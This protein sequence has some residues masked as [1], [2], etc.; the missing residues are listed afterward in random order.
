MSKNYPKEMH[1]AE[2]I[3]SGTMVKRYGVGRPVTTHLEKKKSKV[4]FVFER[5][6]EHDEVAALETTVNDVI[7]QNLI[8]S[9]ELIPRT[10]AESKFDLSRL[11]EETGSSVR[12]VRIGSYD[13]CPCIGS[14][15]R[16]TNEIG[17]FRIIS[18]SHENG[19][20]RIRFTLG[21]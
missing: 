12:I 14:H 10:D 4:D 16:S 21:K 5:N 13:A 15:V 19:L 11:P 1:T 20:L 18:T 3:L 9:E 8:I 17:A 2:H 6:L 7:Q